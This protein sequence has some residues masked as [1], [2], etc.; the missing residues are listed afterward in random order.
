MADPVSSPYSR[1]FLIENGAQPGNSPSYEGLWRAGA[2]SFGQGDV[3]PIRIPDAGS[4][5]KFKTIGTIPGEQDLPELAITARYTYDLSD[6]LRLVNIGCNHDLHVH[7]GTCQNPNDFNDGWTKILVLE[8]ARVSDYGTT[9]LGALEPGDAAPVNEDVT[10]QGQLVYEIK[11]L[12]ATEIASTNITREG[13][14]IAICDQAGCGGVCGA[15]SD[16]CQKVFIVTTSSGGSPGLPA[17]VIYSDDGMATSGKTQVD[18][19]LSSESPD[20]A[21]CVGSNLVVL[22]SASVSLHYAP[23]ADILAGTETW[24]EVTTG[25][26]ATKGPRAGWSIGPNETWIVGAGGY[27]YF[28]TNPASGV[29]VQD[30]GVA[31]TQNLNDVHAID[32]DHAVAVGASNAVVRTVDGATW[33]SKTGPAVGVA[34]NAV[35]MKTVDI[36]LVG[37]AGGKLYYTKNGGDSWTE[38]GFTGSGAGAVDDIYFVNGTVGFMAHR[39]AAPV[40]RVLRTIDG[41]QSWEVMPDSGTMPDND[42]INSIGA[43]NPNTVYGT[44]LG[45]GASD[46]FA[47]KL[48]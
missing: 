12:S 30:A 48:T 46:G 4:Y 22:S 28:A 7:F 24:T 1:V 40:G 15:A 10:W 37:T 32:S 20:D 17:D 25:F 42:G 26:V 27:V 38:I 44:G 29:E 6:M 31:T 18:S 35:W 21:L 11:L 5:G 45:G 36:W 47:V 33:G 8:A 13:L 19:L 14:A 23:T 34:L 43:C 3:T 41:G 39:T 9:D 16:G 2:L